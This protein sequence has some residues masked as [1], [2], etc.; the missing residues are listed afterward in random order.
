M[1]VSTTPQSIDESYDEFRPDHPNSRRSRQVLPQHPR[2]PSSDS[3]QGN[4]RTVGASSTLLPVAQC[5]NADS[6]G[7][8]EPLLGQSDEA[9]QS[10]DILA[11]GDAPP[12]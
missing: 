2:V 8:G 5:M 1:I 11:P 6:E 4:R 9:T 3:K 12:Q 10:D 7:R